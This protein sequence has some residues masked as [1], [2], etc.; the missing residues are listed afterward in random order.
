[1]ID[2]DNRTKQLETRSYQ[3]LKLGVGL[4][5]AVVASATMAS[6]FTAG[7]PLSRMAFGAAFVS[8]LALTLISAP[9]LVWA[10]FSRRRP[11]K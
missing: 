11:R 6:F 8:G 1:M 9:F 4:M 10:I 5:V 2:N 7:S 3:L